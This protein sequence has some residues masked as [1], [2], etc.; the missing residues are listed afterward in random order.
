MEHRHSYE[1]ALLAQEIRPAL[2]W[3]GVRRTYFRHT[4]LRV[5]IRLA[6]AVSTT[7]IDGVPRAGFLTV[8]LGNSP[9]YDFGC[10]RVVWSSG[11]SEEHAGA[12]L[13]LL[14]A[15]LMFPA[16]RHRYLLATKNSNTATRW[17]LQRSGLAL[18][19]RHRAK[20]ACD[21]RYLG[22]LARLR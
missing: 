1:I 18:P 19:P 14:G 4:Y 7:Y 22:W 20:L 21:P 17:L 3:I 13:S 5:R 10:E 6:G 2:P 8:R 16:R 9:Y 11:C 15:A 12:A